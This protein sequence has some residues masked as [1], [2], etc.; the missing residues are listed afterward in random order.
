VGGSPSR[1]SCKL[2]GGRKN[3]FKLAGWARERRS[4]VAKFCADKKATMRLPRKTTIDGNRIHARFK[5]VAGISGDQNIE[6]N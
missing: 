5:T 4:G 2:T 6:G 3:F 1:G